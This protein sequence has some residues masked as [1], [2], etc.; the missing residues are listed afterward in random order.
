MTWCSRMF[1]KSTNTFTR[2]LC[3]VFRSVDIYWLSCHKNTG[4]LDR[5][6]G[7][8][9]IGPAVDP[10]LVGGVPMGSNEY[11]YGGQEG[12]FQPLAGTGEAGQC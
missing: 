2:I 1:H 4:T 10:V 7:V 6:P 3:S 5:V 12:F 11:Q 9:M 8:V